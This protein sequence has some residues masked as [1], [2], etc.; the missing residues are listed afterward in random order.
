MYSRLPPVGGH[1][2]NRRQIPGE[3]RR[4]E[5]DVRQGAAERLLPGQVLGGPEHQP[6]G[7]VERLLRRHQPV[8]VFAVVDAFLLLPQHAN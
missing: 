5:G 6:G 7:R 4:P 8:S 3:E 1:P 2:T